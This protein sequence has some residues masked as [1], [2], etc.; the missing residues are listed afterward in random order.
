[1]KITRFILVASLVFLGS[2]AANAQKKDKGKKDKQAKSTTMS[3]EIKNQTDSA[4]YSLGVLFGKNL[5][6]QGV[7]SLNY[8]LFMAGVR[9][10]IEKGQLKISEQQATQYAQDYMR[11]LSGVKAKKNLDEGRKFLAE[12]RKKPGVQVTESGLQYEVLKQG[13]GPKPTDLNTSVTAHYHGTLIDG[14][15]FDSSVNR[16]QPF[17]TRVGQVIKA[18]QEALLMMNVGTKLRIYCPSEIAYGERGAGQMIGPNMVLIFEMEL[19]SI[20]N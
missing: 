16:N 14:T 20:D 13:T 18:W 2:V 17:K 3:T 11:S 5:A 4:S 9:D 19:I 8:E 15:V 7:D 10:M 6:Q 1:M 12:N